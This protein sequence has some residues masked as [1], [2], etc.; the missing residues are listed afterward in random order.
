MITRLNN[1]NIIA[2][3]ANYDMVFADPKGKE[4]CVQTCWHHPYAL[5]C[6]E[7]REYDG[8][9][10]CKDIR[11][12]HDKENRFAGCH[13]DRPWHKPT[14]KECAK[15]FPDAC[16]DDLDKYYDDKDDLERP[17]K[18]YLALQNREDQS[19]EDASDEKRSDTGESSVVNKEDSSEG[20][21][22]E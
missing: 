20:D 17:H 6:K 14:C 21:R 19:S 4:V 2:F 9:K 3:T 11:C 8:I 7:D 13:K 18:D 22:Y 16:A 12:D 15:L 10:Y 5:K 1:N